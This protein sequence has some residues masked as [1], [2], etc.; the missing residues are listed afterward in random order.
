MRDVPGDP[1][2][3]RDLVEQAVVARAVTAGKI[4]PSYSGALVIPP[5]NPPNL[6]V[7]RTPDQGFTGWGASSAALPREAR[8]MEFP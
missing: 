7:W 8:Q 6:T 2:Q 3:P 5:V 4:L 1:S